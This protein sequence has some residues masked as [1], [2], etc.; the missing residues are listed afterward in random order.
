MVLIRQLPLNNPVN[1]RHGI[2]TVN[3]ILVVHLF[4]TN[5]FTHMTRRFMKAQRQRA[6]CSSAFLCGIMC[7]AEG[8][9][10]MR[11]GIVHGRKRG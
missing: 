5:D 4:A 11:V 6:P 3:S 9:V 10:I 1:A 8:C 2:R 7:C